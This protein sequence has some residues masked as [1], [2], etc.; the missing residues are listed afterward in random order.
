[1]SSHVIIEPENCQ[2]TDF[3]PDTT[4]LDRH[5]AMD[6]LDEEYRA[7]ELEPTNPMGK[8]LLADKLLQLAK[9][10]PAAE[11]AQPSAWATE[12]ARCVS[13]VMQRPVVRLDLKNHVIGY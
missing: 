13:A 10:R 9:S 6:W 11:F 4:G 8:L 5:S 7:A 2:P 1:M 3:R 12:F